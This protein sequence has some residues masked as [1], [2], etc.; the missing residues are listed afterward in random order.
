MCPCEASSRPCDPR[1]ID[2]VVPSHDQSGHKT[3]KTYEIQWWVVV[4]ILL[5]G[6]A[7]SVTASQA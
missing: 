6:A 5:G 2:L 4:L 1:G 7:I 3:L